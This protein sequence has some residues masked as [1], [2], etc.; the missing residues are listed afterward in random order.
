MSLSLWIIIF[1]ILISGAVTK[2]VILSS[3]DITYRKNKTK[4]F[5]NT[6]CKHEYVNYIIS[7]WH[8]YLWYTAGLGTGVLIMLIIHFNL[9]RRVCCPNIHILK[10]IRSCFRTAWRHF[11]IWFRHFCLGQPGIN[12]Y[13]LSTDNIETVR[14]RIRINTHT[15]S[16]LP[17]SSLPFTYQPSS[18]EQLQ[19]TSRQSSAQ[20]LQISHQRSS[21][22]ESQIISEPRSTPQ[23]QLL[24]SVALQQPNLIH[25][26]RQSSLPSPSEL[27]KV[28]PANIYPVSAQIYTC[29]ISTMIA[30]STVTPARISSTVPADEDFVTPIFSFKC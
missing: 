25:I 5:S 8:N 14:R 26:S 12:E 23:S 11:I 10:R 27:V 15:M 6:I 19:I 16:Q 20:E 21:T 29:A 28:N 2:N 4:E 3:M 22:Q 9:Y 18:S 1:T 24:S 7:H 13:S 17:R 30:T